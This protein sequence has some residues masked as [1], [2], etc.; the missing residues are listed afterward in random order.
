MNLKKLIESLNSH[1]KKIL[2]HL[3][4][5][6]IVNICKKANL[7]KVAVI[8]ALEFL[9]NKKIIEL[10][11]F[12][13]KIINLGLNG[14][15]YRKKGLPERRFLNLLGEVKIININQ[16]KEKSLLNNEEFKISIGTLKKKGM[17]KI[18][19]KKI[20]LNTNLEEIAKKTIEEQLIEKLPLKLEEFTQEQ[21]L[22]FQSLIKR[23]DILIVKDEKIIKIKLT[24]LGK[25][26][27]TYALDKEDLIEQITP[28][29]LRKDS[30]WKGKKFRRYDV[31]SPVP[32][33][34]GGKIHF[35]N[36][37]IN[38]A[39]KVWLEMGFEEMS[40][41][42]VQSSFWNFDA[43]FTP[44]DHPA[45]EMQDTFFLNKKIDLTDKDLIKKIKKSHEEG[46]DNSS[47][48]NYNWSEEEAKKLVLRTHTTCLSA[49]TLYKLSKRTKKEGKFF[50]IGK[51]FRNETIDWKH[52]FEFYQTEGIVVSKKVN[53]KDLLGYLK[54]FYKKMGFSKVKF[55][56]GYF[57]Y[58]EPSVEIDVWNPIKEEWIELGGAGIFRPEVTIPLIGED[59]KVLAWGLGFDRII[60]DYYKIKDLRELYKNNFDYL[61]KIKNWI[62]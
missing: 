17:I 6:N 46:I 57:P 4:E 45:R 32:E 53:L 11:Y 50:S 48:W 27:K 19:N 60:T 58:T 31:E 33:I 29:L 18:K 30:N 43:L 38:Y 37:A 40:G 12:K 62:K 36:Q 3:G 24:K 16:A 34:N 1:E 5:K 22:A 23:K 9:N 15:I 41:N 44:Q 14:L 54:E 42:L 56:P 59:F 7:D 13:N 51:V 26:I 52:G 28:E 8:R 47:G 25:E 49:Q 2:P 20:I 39:K 10:L 55:R 21:N 61:K 35:V